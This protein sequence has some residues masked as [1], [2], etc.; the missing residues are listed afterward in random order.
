MKV[1]FLI[2]ML[3]G[4]I[5][6]GGLLVCSNIKIGEISSG[7]I[8]NTSDELRITKSFKANPGIKLTI[9]SEVAD[10]LLQSHE[11]NEI[12]VD[13]YAKG[14]PERLK[15]FNMTFDEGENSLSITIKHRRKF[16]ALK[17]F[18]L[19]EDRWFEQA[20]LIV[21]APESLNVEVKSAGGDIKIESFRGEFELSSAGGD[22]HGENLNGTI[23]AHSAGGD[24]RLRNCSGDAELKS[25]GGDI[26]VN[27]YRGKV[28]AKSSGGDI[29]IN[30]LTG[31]AEA[32]SSGGDIKVDFASSSGTTILSS[33]GGDV[34]IFAPPDLN[35]YV[36][37]KS[38]GG[39]IEV[40][41]P[42]KIEE[43]TRFELKGRIGKTRASTIIASTSGGDI[44][45]R[46]SGE[47]I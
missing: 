14:S 42:V 29:T 30:K 17:L 8:N 44:E 10:V 15:E 36:D 23:R 39:N 31:S 22:I 19:F 35:A 6:A 2:F 1:K 16:R 41:F 27:F 34:K 12:K 21:Y 45:L 18:D 25:S 47:Q 5:F 13:F 11:S 7:E 26:I 32:S 24:L 20:R 33:S 9:S 40:D 4:L 43:K 37:L 38:Y 28:E 46:M 3:T